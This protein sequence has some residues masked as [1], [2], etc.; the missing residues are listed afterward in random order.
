MG[1]RPFSPFFVILLL[2]AVY[3]VIAQATFAM[4]HPW[5]TDTERFQ[6]QKEAITFQ[7]VPRKGGL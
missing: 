6:R 3:Y 4:R 5:M 1:R 2:L 7:T